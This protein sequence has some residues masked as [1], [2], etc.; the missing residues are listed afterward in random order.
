MRGY[1]PLVGTDVLT[2]VEKSLLS[3]PGLS[4]ESRTSALY[5]RIGGWYSLLKRANQIGLLPSAGITTRPDFSSLMTSREFSDKFSAEMMTELEVEAKSVLLQEEDLISALPQFRRVRTLNSGV[6]APPSP[7]F[8]APET[9]ST[10]ASSVSTVRVSNPLPQK[11]MWEDRLSKVL[12][13][14]ISARYIFTLTGTVPVLANDG[15]TRILM[16]VATKKAV[17][18]WT[19]EEIA[20]RTKPGDSSMYMEFH[21]TG[22]TTLSEAGLLNFVV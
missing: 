14:L 1:I 20:K 12:D 7:D 15:V 9:P 16:D 22:P 10:V 3:F 8:L 4:R 21:T 6:D 2:D 13:K 19:D 5:T 18:G 11:D 17:T